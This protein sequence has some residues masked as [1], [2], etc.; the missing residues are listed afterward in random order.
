[1][2]GALYDRVLG[3]AEHPRAPWFLGGLSFVESS[4]FPIPPDVMLA[5]MV[6]ARPLQ[7]VRYAILTTVASVLGGVFG[8]A[9]GAWAYDWVAPWLQ[10]GG[11]HGFAEAQRVFQ[12]WG[13]WI[14]LVAAF[15]PIPYK[16][17]T[18][19]AGF[20]SLALV[21]FV[22]ASLLG[23]GARYFLV[24]ALVRWAG[25][26]CEPWLRDRIEPIGWACVAILV[27]VLAVREWN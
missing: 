18:L 6:L 23:R 7:W 25:P 19:S 16:A 11:L 5:P 8:Y 24:A 10:A 9:L 27:L 15:S 21:P 17:F 22:L 13:V 2:F 26:R 12:E 1:M 14:V 3:W 20:M 4:V